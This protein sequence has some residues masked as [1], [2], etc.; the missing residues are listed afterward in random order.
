MH[1]TV[2]WFVGCSRWVWPSC[3]C[4]GGHCAVAVSRRQC[5]R[6]ARMGVHIANP[7]QRGCATNWLLVETA[8][9]VA[10]QRPGPVGVTSCF[11]GP[12][13]AWRALACMDAI[14]CDFEIKAFPLKGKCEHVTV[15]L[16]CRGFIQSLCGISYNSMCIRIYIPSCMLWHTMRALCVCR[17]ANIHSWPRFWGSCSWLHPNLDNVAPSVTNKSLI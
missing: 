7:A 8:P 16:I 5:A 9:C 15:L 10:H 13:P 3:A 4:T 11:T 1:S 12:L 2:R 6:T 14:Y 17:R